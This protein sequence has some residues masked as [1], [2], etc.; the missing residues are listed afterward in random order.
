MPVARRVDNSPNCPD[1][2]LHVPAARLRDLHALTTPNRPRPRASS[3]DVKLRVPYECGP[4]GLRYKPWR[5]A[6]AL[7]VR[8]CLFLEV[9]EASVVLDCVVDGDCLHFVNGH[10]PLLEKRAVEAGLLQRCH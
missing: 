2:E 6:G 3:Y 9:E 5:V 8:L 7:K 10:T 4:S 1:R